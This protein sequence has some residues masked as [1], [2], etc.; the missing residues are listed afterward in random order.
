ME[1]KVNQRMCQKMKIPKTTPL[2]TRKM[3]TTPLKK[4]RKR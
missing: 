1:E 4:K 3:K 2:V